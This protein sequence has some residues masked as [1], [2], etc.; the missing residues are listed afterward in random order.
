M[1]WLLPLVATAQDKIIDSLERVLQQSKDDTAKLVLLNDLCMRYRPVN[2]KKGIEYGWRAIPLAKKT[3]R[4]KIEASIYNNIGNSYNAQ[5]SYDSALIYF[6]RSVDKYLEIGDKKGAAAPTFNIGSVYQY[7]GD[8]NVSLKYEIESLRLNEA[9]DNKFG[10]ASSCNGIGLVYL[11][12]KKPAEGREYFKRALEIYTALDNKYAMVVL[13][14]NI[15]LSYEKERDYEKA[16][17]YYM[18]AMKLVESIGGDPYTLAILYENIG[19]MFEKEKRFDKTFEYLEKS[20]KLKI[21]IN[22]K[23]G[24]TRS[25]R[26]LANLHDTLG[27][28]Q[29]FLEYSAKALALAKEIG[30]KTYIRDVDR[31]LADHYEK[32]NDYKNAY[33]FF[34]EYAEVKDSVLNEESSKQIAEAQTKYD[35]EKKEKEI[36]LLNKDREKQSA[37][38]TA[39]RKQKNIIIGS[40]AAVLLIVIIFSL[41]LFQRFRITQKQKNIIE[42]QKVIVEQKR[43]EAEHQRE[44][45]EEK[46]KEILDSINY[47]RRIQQA[48]LASESL[49]NSNLGDHFVLFKPKDI[50]SGDF[51]WATEHEDKFYL[52]VCDSTGHGVPGAFMSLLNIGFLSEGIKEKS[53]T[54]PKEVFN[55]VRKRLV[56]SIS[57]EGQKD[58]FDGILLCIDK[59]K[60]EYSYAAA[61]NSPVLAAQNTINNLACDKMPVGQGERTESF[62]THVLN[63][64]AG[65]TLYLYTDGYADQFGGP[66]G[67]KFKYKQL[68]ELLLE[69]NSLPMQEQKDVLLAKFNDWKGELEQVDD[70]LLI[71][72]RL[73]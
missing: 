43:A 71:G 49:L 55:Y 36:E 58:G 53:I 42:K 35:T 44:L 23:E 40:V 73:N 70:V 20:L 72:V 52:A 51:Y 2:P 39:E 50:V 26:N 67:K 6:K 48:L 64:V 4:K 62:S 22:D 32:E 56:D 38:T 47:A 46:Q 14:S 13:I 61:H 31:D 19:G 65:N 11:E 59:K 1:I 24:I 68:E 54:D 15:G 12:L 34:K 30:G 33:T 45:V 37:I 10:I 3:G 8:L 27:H 17:D 69:V 29:K 41:F 16:L 7:K 5:A 60:K 66:R 63:L 25:Y 21:E 18:K 28:K 9:A 57:K